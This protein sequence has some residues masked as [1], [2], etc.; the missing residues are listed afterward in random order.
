MGRGTRAERTRRGAAE[1]GRDETVD[2]EQ[3]KAI[4]CLMKYACENLIDGRRTLKDVAL[5]LEQEIKKK[6]LSFF[7]EGGYVAAGC[8]IPRYFELYAALCR[9]RRP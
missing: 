6:G 5:L 1:C 3:V 4:A 7:S 9:Y 8:A 2:D